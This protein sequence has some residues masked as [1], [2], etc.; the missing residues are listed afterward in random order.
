MI[1]KSREKR[2]LIISFLAGLTF[3]VLELLFAL[4]S[5][6][7]S[8]LTDAMYDTTELVFVGL[9]VFLIP[10]FH[11]PI[12]EKRPYGYFQIESI[13]LIVKGFMMLS[14]SLSVA[15]EVIDSA[16]TGGN[17]VNYRNVFW[18]QLLL[19]VMSIVIYFIM[20]K[21]TC[22]KP[23]PT[24]TAELLGWKLDI[25][26]SLGMATGFLCAVFL[27]KTRLGFLA[28][29]FDQIVAVIVMLFMLPENIKIIWHSI[30][31]LFLFSPEAGI[32]EEIKTT[33]GKIMRDYC[34]EPVFYEITRTG[35]HLWV[36]I[37]FR[38]SKEALNIA[39]LK[40]VHEL[41][42][43]KLSAKFTEFTCELVLNP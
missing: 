5:H 24:V 42:N 26:N 21:L 19:G 33:C 41:V 32:V 28:P 23:S 31:D 27:E 34:F 8:A 39:D 16:L 11:R 7:Q 22:S 40:Q 9:L 13:F 30:R 43:Q 15:M 38:I 3:A 36:T 29:Y 12:S 14:V 18:F 20:K 25:A 10:L 37:D 35:R 4:F 2:I 6:S 1:S 17:P